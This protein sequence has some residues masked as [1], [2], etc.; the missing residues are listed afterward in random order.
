VILMDFGVSKIV[1]AN[2]DGQRLGYRHARVYVSGTGVRPSVDQRADLYALGI[3]L[4][5]LVTGQLP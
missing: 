3:I 4:Y 1:C 2:S 5:Q